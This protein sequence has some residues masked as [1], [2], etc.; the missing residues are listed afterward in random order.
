MWLVVVWVGGFCGF[1]LVVVFT[2]GWMFV[3]DFVLVITRCWWCGCVGGVCFGDFGGLVV[4]FVLALLIC[5]RLGF[6]FGVWGGW[7]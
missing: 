7:G 4:L 2:V 3:L 1:G 6:W 5:V